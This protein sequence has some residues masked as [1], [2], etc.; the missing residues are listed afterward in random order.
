MT[1]SVC[2]Q[3]IILEKL[4]IRLLVHYIN[5]RCYFLGIYGT[6]RDQMT[7][8]KIDDT[9]GV[10]S[11]FN[12]TKNQCDRNI[13][14]IGVVRPSYDKSYDAKFKICTGYIHHDVSKRHYESSVYPKSNNFLNYY[15]N[16]VYVN[17]M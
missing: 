5:E 10:F 9:L 4:V 12:E 15:D 17:D 13:N 2:S 11:T 8:S 16:L 7:C 3:I 1:F 14:C 6:K